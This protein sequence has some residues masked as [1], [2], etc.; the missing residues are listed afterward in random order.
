[1]NM[2]RRDLLIGGASI[3]GLALGTEAEAADGHMIVE[4]LYNRKIFGLIGVGVRESVGVNV[5]VD[6]A[7]GDMELYRSLLPDALD[8]PSKPRLMIYLYNFQKTHPVPI[9]GGYR[10]AAV[11]MSA[12][13][14]RDTRSGP[15]DDG[16]H[17]LEMPV[18]SQPAL[19]GGLA[20]GYPK[21]MAEISLDEDGGEWTGGVEGNPRCLM[22]LTFSPEEVEVPWKDDLE[23]SETFYLFKG[24]PDNLNIMSQEIVREEVAEKTT[25]TI[26]LTLDTDREW[27]ELLP[28]RDLEA[29]AVMRTFRGLGLLTRRSE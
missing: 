18:S 21:F 3:L 8:L 29:P 28:D 12:K 25:G 10:E 19:W 14:S 15:D 13:C 1:M 24:S 9:R 23:L 4:K 11:C 26:S 6:V 22:E 20:L 2:K 5:F 17:V 16:W 7:D 27:I